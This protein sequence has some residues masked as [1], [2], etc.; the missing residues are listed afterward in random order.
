MHNGEAFVGF[1][2]AP[3]D[4]PPTFK[5]DVLRSR[6]SKHRSSKRMSKNPVAE[7]IQLER[8]EKQLTEIEERRTEVDE[9]GVKSDDEI[10]IEVEGD[11]DNEAV[12]VA[13]TSYS[14]YTDTEDPEKERYDYFL[15]PP[16]PRANASTG[17]LVNKVLYS[18]AAHKAKAKWISLISSPHTPIGK[19]KKGHRQGA[20]S[21]SVASSSYASAYAYG[22][23]PSL[24][25]Q[26]PE[27]PQPEFK[28]STF[29]PT[30]DPSEAYKEQEGQFLTPTRSIGSS[31]NA[32][33]GVPNAL[34]G[35]ANSTRSTNKSDEKD[36]DEAEK[37]NYDSSHKQRVPSW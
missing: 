2:E 4:F 10:E 28:T 29:P 1:E 30:P 18:A 5:Y 16:S 3:I 7:A 35:R 12:S 20:D 19:W 24:S 37:F 31:E 13:S 34:A 17:N 15:P 26:L 27:S 8:H 21:K 11:G 23:E 32:R 6:R 25:P 22:T 36:E 14:R 33:L 9:D